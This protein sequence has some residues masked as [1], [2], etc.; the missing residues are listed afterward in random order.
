MK[1]MII[2]HSVTIDKIVLINLKKYIDNIDNNIII[3]I[4]IYFR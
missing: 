1:N 3:Y 4:K 2:F